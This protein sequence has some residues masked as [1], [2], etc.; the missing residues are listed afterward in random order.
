M[1]IL[2]LDKFQ[3]WSLKI[4]ED[5]FRFLDSTLDESFSVIQSILN[6]PVSREGRAIWG[7]KGVKS[8][9]EWELES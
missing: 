4:P 7:N 3:N 8:S 6:E 9:E 1:Y 2:L 5:D